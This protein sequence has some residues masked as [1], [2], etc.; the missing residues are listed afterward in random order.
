MKK[1]TALVAAAALLAFV[2]IML[3]IIN[4]STAT[5][6]HREGHSRGGTAGGDGNDGRESFNSGVLVG[7]MF[8]F[9]AVED[10]AVS[11]KSK[12]AISNSE[13]IVK[14]SKN[15]ETRTFL[16]FDVS[17]VSGPVISAKVLLRSITNSG[18][19]GEL[20]DVADTGDFQP[21]C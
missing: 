7:G 13:L 2:S 9:T 17:D 14:R 3:V 10:I 11:S 18:Y 19:G 20:R 5:A 12:P 16:M 15:A 4:A 6:H 21:R 8:L 1:I